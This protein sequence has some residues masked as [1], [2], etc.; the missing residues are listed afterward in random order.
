MADDVAARRAARAVA[1]AGDGGLEACRAWCSAR[2]SRAAPCR[3]CSVLAQGGSRCPR[4]GCHSGSLATSPS[5][6]AR[7]SRSPSI[8]SSRGAPPNPA[9]SRCRRYSCTAGDH[10]PI[11]RSSWSPRRTIPAVIRPPPTGTSPS[12]GCW[13]PVTPP[14]SQREDAYRGQEEARAGRRP[15]ARLSCTS[16]TALTL[17]QITVGERVK[18]SSRVATDRITPILWSELSASTMSFLSACRLVVDPFSAATSL[19]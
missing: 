1:V 16:L 17:I 6:K 15:E 3:A 11:G 7:T 19:T 13:W 8:P 5:M 14:V 10:D 2:I 18:R 12:P 4:P 9:A